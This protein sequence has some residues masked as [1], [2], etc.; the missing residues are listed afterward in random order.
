MCYLQLIC[1]KNDY[2][3]QRNTITYVTFL[4]IL[5]DIIFATDNIW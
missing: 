4:V 1:L 3:G 5:S 2:I